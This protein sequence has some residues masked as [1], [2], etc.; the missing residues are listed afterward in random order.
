MIS[1]CMATYN[2]ELFLREQIDSILIQLGTSDELVVSDDGSTDSTL[3]ILNSYDDNRIKLIKNNGIKG[4]TNNFENALKHSCGDIIFLSDQDDIWLPNKVN[5]CVDEIVYHDFLVHDAS[6]V[7]MD[8]NVLFK[9]YFSFRKVKRGFLPNFYKIGYLGCCMVFKRNVLDKA[10]PFPVHDKVITH[11][12]WLT[13]IAELYFKTKLLEN[14]LI[15]YRRHNTN[16]SLGGGHGFNSIF[17]KLKIRFFSLV[18]L[19]MKLLR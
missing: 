7:N 15:L 11:D 13:L 18:Y 12:S 16:T 2:G 10:L 5:L 6:V 4:Y 1:V 19:V 9:S 14:P 3:T 17:F 8:R